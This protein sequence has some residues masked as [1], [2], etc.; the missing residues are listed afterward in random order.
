MRQNAC[1]SLG[2][3]TRRLNC[4]ENLH[5]ADK[6]C[7]GGCPEQEA[8]ELC[9]RWF[10]AAAP[11]D[12]H[13][14]SKAACRLRRRPARAGTLKDGQRTR[15]RVQWNFS[16]GGDLCSG[17]SEKCFYEFSRQSKCKFD[18]RH[19]PSRELDRPTINQP[20]MNQRQR[21]PFPAS[22]RRAHREEK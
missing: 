14:C 13:I 9:S 17:L 18:L 12:Q 2:Q 4:R 15:A 16:V 1:P 7:R 8:M 3:K 10:P 22:D 21:A 5:F 6:V 11:P 19:M 20:T